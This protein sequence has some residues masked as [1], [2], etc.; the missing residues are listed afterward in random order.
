MSALDARVPLRDVHLAV[1]HADQTTTIVCDRGASDFE[2]RR[3]RHGRLRDQL[4]ARPPE[5]PRGQPA[6][7]TACSELRR[8][9]SAWPDHLSVQKPVDRRHG[10]KLHS[11][12][13]AAPSRRRLMRPRA[14]G[15]GVS[16]GVLQARLLDIASGLCRRGRQVL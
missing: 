16:T 4:L 9:R 2:A 8:P 11:D 12:V 5:P 14:A 3:V 7:Q 6:T 1:R 10:A 15:W 13:V